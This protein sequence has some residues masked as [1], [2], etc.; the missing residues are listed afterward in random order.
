VNQYLTALVVRNP[1]TLPLSKD[2]TYTENDQVLEIG[3]GF[4]KTVEGR[5]ACSHSF[6]DPEAS[7][8]HGDDE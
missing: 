1:S 4:W 8:L 2:L 6:A 7:R 3:D 5:G